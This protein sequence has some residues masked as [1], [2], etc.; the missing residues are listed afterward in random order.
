MQRKALKNFW[1]YAA[2][3]IEKGVL[4]A[5]GLSVVPIPNQLMSGCNLGFA[6]V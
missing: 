2:K 3:L 4:P 5:D 1:Q 6:D